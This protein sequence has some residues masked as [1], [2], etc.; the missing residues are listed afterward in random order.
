[1]C[2]R[3]GLLPVPVRLAPIGVAPTTQ[4]APLISRGGS[5]LGRRPRRARARRRAVPE[6]PVARPA[7]QK[8][9]SAEAADVAS[10]QREHEQPRQLDSAPRDMRHDGRGARRSNEAHLQRRLG[11]PTSGRRSLGDRPRALRC[12]APTPP[13]TGDHPADPAIARP[14]FSTIASSRCTR[15]RWVAERGRAA[16]CA[17]Q[18]GVD[19]D[20]VAPVL[21]A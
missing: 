5:A 13:E 18:R 3:H 9:A 2:I 10:E 1:M 6:A 21:R 20:A 17:A 12:P 19:V 7:Q 8:R 11:A 4:C 15:R 16:R 14:R